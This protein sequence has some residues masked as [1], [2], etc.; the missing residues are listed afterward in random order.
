MPKLSELK[1]VIGLS[2]EGLRQL[3]TDLRNTQGKFKKNFGQISGMVQQAGRNM[4][5]G[6]TAPLGIMAAQSVK[7]FDEQQ[8]A[9]HEKSKAHKVRCRCG[10]ERQSKAHKVQL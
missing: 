2:K 7:A 10:V 6:L 4:T 9:N 1:V 5:I 8:K 3:N